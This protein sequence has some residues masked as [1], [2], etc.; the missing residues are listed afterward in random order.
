MNDMS[1]LDGLPPR[2]KE[3]V[4]AQAELFSDRTTVVIDRANVTPAPTAAA[5]TYTVPFRL[6]GETSGL[7]L[8]YTGTIAATVADTSTSGTATVSSASPTI[9]MGSGTVNILGDAQA[10]LNAETATLT[11]TY[12]NLRGGTDTDT[13][14]VTFT[15]P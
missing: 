9:T 8:P 14:V 12:T 13:F 15:T 5:W 10:W 4:S 2:M 3:I 7:V 1:Y 11:L 6:V